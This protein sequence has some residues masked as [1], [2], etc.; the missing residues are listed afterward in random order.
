MDNLLLTP[1][2]LKELVSAAGYYI[3]LVGAQN[4]CKAQLAKCRNRIEEAKVEGLE[5]GKALGRKEV[6]EFVLA[7][8]NQGGFNY[9]MG[10]Y[11]EATDIPA[12]PRGTFSITPEPS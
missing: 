10:R 8:I 4:I 7:H 11:S 9:E 1:E 3:W 6:V 2:K 12:D 5:A